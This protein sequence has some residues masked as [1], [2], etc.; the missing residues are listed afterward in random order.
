MG[1]RCGDNDDEFFYVYGDTFL[2]CGARN[3]FDIVDGS[4]FTCSQPILILASDE[5]IHPIPSV[6]IFTDYRWPLFTSERCYNFTTVR[7]RE[8]TQRGVSLEETFP[9]FVSS[10][11]SPSHWKVMFVA[12]AL[13][14]AG[15]SF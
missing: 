13:A 2:E 14:V 15:L 7:R 12:V 5:E 4:N 1:I 10:A 11:S 3:K 8:L 6:E 9:D